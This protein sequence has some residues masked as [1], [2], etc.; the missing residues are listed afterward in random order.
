MYSETCARFV[1]TCLQTF[2]ISIF[3]VGDP[4]KLNYLLFCNNLKTQFSTKNN[5]LTPKCSDAEDDGNDVQTRLSY[6]SVFVS[7]CFWSIA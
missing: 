2:K 7:K 1:N 4:I 5:N 3:K 6:T